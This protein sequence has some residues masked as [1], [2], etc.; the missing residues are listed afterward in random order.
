[1]YHG[2][3]ISYAGLEG[4]VEYVEG[5]LEAEFQYGYDSGWGDSSRTEG[6]GTGDEDSVGTMNGI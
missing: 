3:N 6:A 1:N 5:L 2:T 4:L